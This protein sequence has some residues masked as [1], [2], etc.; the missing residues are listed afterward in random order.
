M[1]RHR[2]QTYITD[3]YVREMPKL[4]LD[5]IKSTVT[6]TSYKIQYGKVIKEGDKY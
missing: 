5:N 4:D 2:Y 3:V 1:M 6:H